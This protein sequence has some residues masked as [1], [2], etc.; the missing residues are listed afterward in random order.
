MVLSVPAKVTLTFG[1]IRSMAR[2]A[3]SL[4]SKFASHYFRLFFVASSD[5]GSRKR[6]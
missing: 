6:F 5:D 3:N 1:A 2:D 4:T